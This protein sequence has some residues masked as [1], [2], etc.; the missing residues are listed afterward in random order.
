MKLHVQNMQNIQNGLNTNQIH[1]YLTK[2]PH[3]LQPTDDSE[4]TI[5]QKQHQN[6]TM[7]RQ[8]VQ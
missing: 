8:G 4:K 3:A 5:M 1:N 6:T 7:F 2:N